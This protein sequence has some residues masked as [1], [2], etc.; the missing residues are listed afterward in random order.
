MN[1]DDEYWF[2]M[3]EAQLKVGVPS[4]FVGDI[5][6]LAEKLKQLH[7]EKEDKK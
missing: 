7:N 1:K 5:F 4:S 6:D 2:R 3:A